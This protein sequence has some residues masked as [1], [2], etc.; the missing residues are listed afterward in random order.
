MP[1]KK[2]LVIDDSTMIR[3]MVSGIL[4][5]HFEVLEASDGVMGLQMAKQHHPDLILLDF[6]MP[7]MDG[8]DTLRHIRQEESLRRTPI[9]IMSGLKEQVTARIPEPFK[10]FD[11]IEKPFE[12]DVLLDRIHHH[13]QITPQPTPPPAA[14]TEEAG[15]TLL[16]KMTSLE[17]LLIQGMENLVQREVVSRLSILG[18]RLQQQEIKIAS[19]EAKVDHLSKQIEQQNRILVVMM[20]E[21]KQLR[22]LLAQRSK[23]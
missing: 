16:A 8:Y 4:S 21:F 11:F 3:R 14:E 20:N 1:T 10:G 5:K 13:L 6:V 15:Q 22:V 9:I 17:T 19:L 18:K 23:S 12:A 2:V 7:N